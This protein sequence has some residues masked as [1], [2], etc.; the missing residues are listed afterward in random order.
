MTCKV[1]GHKKRLEIDRALLE[2]Q[3]LRVIARRTETTASSLQRHKAEHLARSLVKAHEAREVARADSLLDDVRKAEG[4]AER[5]LEVAEDILDEAREA[6]DLK[7]A[8]GAIRAA[9]GV[10]AERRNFME[11]RG[12]LTGELSNVA[13]APANVPVVIRVLSVPR[14]PGVQTVQG[15]PALP[16]AEPTE[17]AR[18]L[19]VAESRVVD[20]PVDPDRL[21]IPGR[22]RR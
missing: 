2:G 1:C 19:P 22:N 4:R 13:D 8:I 5:L 15:V 11:L 14:M 12:A 6:E 17:E 10:M 21:D 20:A 9:A 16:A 3:S 7:T 18:S